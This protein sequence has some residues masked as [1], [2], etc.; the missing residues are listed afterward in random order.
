MTL[1]DWPCTIEITW[2]DL[3]HPDPSSYN[4]KYLPI[5]D[6]RFAL[7][8]PRQSNP[9][10][11]LKPPRLTCSI[12]ILVLTKTTFL[13]M[14]VVLAPMWQDGCQKSKLHLYNCW[15]QNTVADLVTNYRCI[16][17]LISLNLPAPENWLTREFE[18]REYHCD[19]TSLS[20]APQTTNSHN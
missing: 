9:A 3:G 10:R 12:P 1:P 19:V 4:T 15:V 20:G 7:S 17:W 8:R 18:T 6:K 11:P 2:V 14:A 5:M 16:I 13:A